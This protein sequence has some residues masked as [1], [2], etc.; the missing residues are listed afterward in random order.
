MGSFTH[1]S[2]HTHTTTV[3]PQSAGLAIAVS[4]APPFFP[5]THT[6]KVSSKAKILP[7]QSSLF[8][9]SPA[10]CLC[11]S[12][13]PHRPTF[14]R[15]SLQRQLNRTGR[16]TLVWER[17]DSASPYPYLGTPSPADRSSVASHQPICRRQMK[18]LVDTRHVV[19]V[20]RASRLDIHSKSIAQMKWPINH[21][22]TPA[23]PY[24]SFTKSIFTPRPLPKR[25]RQFRVLAPCL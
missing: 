10:T 20:V 15:R 25:H 23:S 24:N 2:T 14:W 3:S 19:H 18:R 5:T 1:A 6:D 8:V 21:G 17:F 13:P 7:I 4:L 9:W 12:L 11:P 16:R 22:I